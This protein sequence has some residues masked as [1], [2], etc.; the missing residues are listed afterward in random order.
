MLVGTVFISQ[1]LTHVFDIQCRC[2]GWFVGSSFVVG[3]R[4]N[5]RQLIILQW[6]RSVS[7]SSSSIMSNNVVMLGNV[8][9]IISG[10]NGLVSFIL[11]RLIVLRART[12]IFR[13]S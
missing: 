8:K 7:C 11:T 4:E 5:S 1:N 9:V 13:A 6:C 12:Q 10:S 3:Q 2:G